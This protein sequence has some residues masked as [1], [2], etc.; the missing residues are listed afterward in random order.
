MRTAVLAFLAAAC[1]AG[2]AVG[3]TT[4]RGAAAGE[5][6]AVREARALYARVNREHAGYRRVERS[7]LG[8]SAEGASLVGLYRGRELRKLEVTY[9][10]EMGRTTEECYLDA[11]RPVFI[12]RV[13]ERYDRPFGRV[14]R[15]LEDRFY[16]AD[17]RLVRWIDPAGRR[18]PPGSAAFGE[19]ERDALDGLAPLLRALARPDSVYDAGESGGS[20]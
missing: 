5:E 9:Y 15:R 16:F 12:F 1:L 2:S 7:V 13:D 19:A 4:P 3:Q 20:L 10:G 17:G 6:A 18:V 14:A 11:G 8:L